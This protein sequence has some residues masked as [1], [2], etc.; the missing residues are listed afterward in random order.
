M[1]I[2]SENIRLL[3]AKLGKTQRELSQ[4]IQITASRYSSYENGKSKPPVDVL[5]KISRI[6]NV[7]IDLLLSVDLTKH[8]LED[9]L[10]LPDNRIVLPVMVDQNGDESIE[11][12]SQKASMGYLTGYSDPD[13]IESLQRI[14][15][16]FL[17]NGKFRAFPADG[18][19]MPPFKNG[20]Y[21]IGKYV[22]GLNDLKSGNTYVFIT[23]N[24][25]I[26]YKRLKSINENSLTVAA[27]NKFYEPYEIPLNEIVEVWQYA[28]G[29]F[30]EDF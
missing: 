27:D 12:V 28:T 15:L 30:P 8:A 19:S 6:F 1:S 16:P 11:I 3:R 21:I 20:S 26:T 2:F 7:S 14:S 5:I 24:D 4:K 10:K 23:L 18:D 17:K 29:I 25:G 9:M 22:E 13:Y